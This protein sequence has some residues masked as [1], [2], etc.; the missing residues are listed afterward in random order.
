MERLGLSSKLL[1]TL[2]RAGI[3]TF[4]QLKNLP[5]RK[6]AHLPGVGSANLA[7][8]KTALQPYELERVAD[9]QRQI[10]DHHQAIETLEAEI[11]RVRG[12]TSIELSRTTR[13]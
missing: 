10:R 7:V 12:G 6:L 8:L 3:K 5:P 13:Q 4:D 2:E 9:L 1:Y 11:N